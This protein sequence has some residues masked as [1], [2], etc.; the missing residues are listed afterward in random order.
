MNGK[1]VHV[2]PE[3]CIVDKLPDSISNDFNTMRELLSSSRKTPNQ[4][5]NAIEG[6]SK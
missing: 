4:K 2:P 3:L 6:F 5:F 1:E